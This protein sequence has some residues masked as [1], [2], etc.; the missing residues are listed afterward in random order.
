MLLTD[1][2]L[3]ELQDHA[4]SFLSV[5][6]LAI[7]LQVDYLALWQE[8]NRPDSPAAK[9]FQRE[10]LLMKSRIRRGILEL[11]AAGSDPAQS[12]ALRLIERTDFA[13]KA[14]SFKKS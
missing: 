11:A 9:V 12:K 7:I 13:D 4:G 5:R 8:L 2:Q 3:S 14:E 1:E 10:R 6:E